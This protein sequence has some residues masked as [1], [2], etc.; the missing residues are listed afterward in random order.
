MFVILPEGYEV[1]GAGLA[2]LLSNILVLIYYAFVIRSLKGKTVLRFSFPRPLPEKRHMLDVSTT[3]APSAIMNLFYDVLTLLVNRVLSGYGDVA[4]AAMGIVFKVERLPVN[5]DIG[6]CQGMMTLAAYNF[7]QNNTGR[8]KKVF[9]FSRNAGILI[10][11]VCIVL[12]E[13][14]ASGIMRFFIDDAETVQIGTQFLMRRILG[15]P[16]MFL[17][18]LHVFFFQA[19]NEGKT[20][21]QLVFMRFLLFN[22]PL[23]Y[24]LNAIFGMNGVVCTQICGDGLTALV[25]LFVFGRYIRNKETAEQLHD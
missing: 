17:S 25:S 16:F 5:I 13:L 2:T 19:V 11:I 6:F 14:T 1:L 21:L 10:T 4:L 24:V 8:M 18:F 20:G 12:Y 7:A 3:G 23:L 22:I 15:T 9:R